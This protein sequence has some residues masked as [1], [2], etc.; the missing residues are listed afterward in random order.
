MR[1]C[2]HRAVRWVVINSMPNV[3]VG[4]GN[5]AHASR[6]ASRRVAGCANAEPRGAG[7]RRQ[8]LL[9]S[10]EHRN[11]PRAALHATVLL[12]RPTDYLMAQPSFCSV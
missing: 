6:Y 8:L 4:C 3:F 12:N 11:T 2:G 1:R 9:F 5:T 10:G 7:G